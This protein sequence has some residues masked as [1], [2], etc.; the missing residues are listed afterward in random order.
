MNQHV[1]PSKV[2]NIALQKLRSI[3][4]SGI[5]ASYRNETYFHGT[6]DWRYLLG[7]HIV[8]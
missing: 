4:K 7:Y 6:R 2:H 3:C 5:Q 1:L 8:Q